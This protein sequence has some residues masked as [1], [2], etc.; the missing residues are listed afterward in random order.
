MI[1]KIDGPT[2]ARDRALVA[3]LFS[4]GLRSAEFCGLQLQD[5]NQRTGRISV[6]SEVAKGRKFREVYITGKALLL[7]NRWL[8]KAPD[9]DP[10]AAVWQSRSGSGLR[11]EGIRDIVSRACAAAGL[12]GYSFHDFRRGCALEMK[13]AGADI[14][15]ISHFL[16]HADL[17]T[18]ERYL[19]L[20]DTDNL[21]TALRF[22]PLK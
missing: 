9:Q 21:K 17:K 18:T 7:L 6:R 3:V 14:K 4:S 2:A 12:E 22:D 13:R 10:A 5:I 11:P 16:G 1:K 8:K 19:A 15:D 20:D